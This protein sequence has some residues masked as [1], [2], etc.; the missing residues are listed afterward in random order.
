MSNF[1]NMSRDESIAALNAIV[2]RQ[3]ELGKR[4]D[5]LA[6]NIEAKAED[7]KAV[8]RRL[9]ELENRA[10][11]ATAQSQGDAEMRHYVDGERIRWADETTRDG[12]ERKGLITDTPRPDWQRELRTLVSDRNLAKKF[13][14]RGGTPKLDARISEHLAKGPDSVRRIFADGAGIGAEFIPDVLV[15]DLYSAMYEA[16]RV[17]ALFPTLSMPAATTLLPFVTL[18]STPYIGAAPATND[19]AKF[20]ASSDV[21]AQ[22]TLNAKSF[23][24]RMQADDDALEDSI[25]MALPMLRS[26]VV[27]AIVDGVEDA[28]VNGDTAGVGTDDYANWNPRARWDSGATLGTSADHRKNWIGLRHRAFDTSAASDGSS[29]ETFAGFMSAR[30]SLDAPLGTAG[31]LVCITSPEYYLLKMV[32]FDQ[33]IT[34]D[35]MGPLAT[36]LSG[37]LANL[38]GI[39]VVLSAFMTPDLNTAG[40][41]DNTTKTKTSM[42]IAN[43]SRFLV[44]EYRAT[45]VELDREISNGVVNVVATRRVAFG[46]IDSSTKKNVALSYNLTAS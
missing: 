9:H 15:P 21:T 19:P 25:V 11:M 18:G 34:V 28:I 1:D 38:A 32:Q 45:T 46:T 10:H 41:Y 44:G 30:A 27:S 36:V 37:Q 23:R 3:A 26:S 8:S 42:L 13:V 43:V 5:D 40:L 20:T 35:K 6:E 33:V 12:I 16:R 2:E 29:A 4:G 22:R 7:L 39:P 14:A 31:D 24:V 17:E